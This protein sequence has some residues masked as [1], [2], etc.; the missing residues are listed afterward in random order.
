MAFPT[1]LSEAM[2]QCFATCFFHKYKMEDF[3]RTIGVD[4]AL[5]QKHSGT[6]KSVW[7]RAILWELGRSNSGC[8]VQRRVLTALCQLTNAPDNNAKLDRDAALAALSRLRDLAMRYRE[9]LACAIFDTSDPLLDGLLDTARRKFLDSDL[10]DRREALEK[11]W[12]AWERLKTLES[13]D[14]Q[15]SIRLLLDKVCNEP[16]FRR[17]LETEARALTEIGNSFMIRHSEIGRVPIQ[18]DE[19]VDYLF[20]RMFALIRLILRQTGRGG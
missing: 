4:P 8:E 5:I 14:K 20:H 6:M 10:H 3:L 7:A 15:H 11:L 16:A 2:V 17:V 13:S 18:D 19:H 1:E 12:D 9:S